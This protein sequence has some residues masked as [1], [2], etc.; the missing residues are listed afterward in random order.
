MYIYIHMYVNIYTQKLCAYVYI[1][2]NESLCPLKNIKLK[3]K[4]KLSLDITL[5][6]KRGKPKTF[7]F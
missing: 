5:P 7:F 3:S 1:H 4:N 2:T 6:P